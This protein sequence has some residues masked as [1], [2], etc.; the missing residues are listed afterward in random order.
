MYDLQTFFPL[1]EFP[2]FL[3]VV[4]GST[5]IFTFGNVYHRCCHYCCVCFSVISKR[6]LPNPSSWRFIP[7][8]SSKSLV[9][10]AFIVRSL[11]HFELILYMVWG[12][13]PTLFFCMWISTFPSIIC[14]KDYSLS[15]FNYLGTLV[16]NQLSKNMRA[17]FWILSSIPLVFMSMPVLQC[18]D[19]CNFLCTEF[20]NWDLWVLQLCFFSRL[21][22]LFC[23]FWVSI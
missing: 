11:I 16:K 23:F 22:K 1:G 21:F 18:L 7:V 4:F 14:W 19:H 10:L 12:K 6:P 8:F 20:W 3:D 15:I 17:Y 13:S 5:R 2:H 9:L